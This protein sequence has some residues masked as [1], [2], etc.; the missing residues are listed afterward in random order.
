MRIQFGCVPLV[1]QVIEYQRA[2]SAGFF[3]NMKECRDQTL[4]ED[5]QRVFGKKYALLHLNILYPTSFLSLFMY[6]LFVCLD[7]Q[8]IG[9]T[10]W[11]YRTIH[12]HRIEDGGDILQD[13]FT[14]RPSKCLIFKGKI[15]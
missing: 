2:Q 8:G 10:Y 6:T 3:K 7:L 11:I 4:R 5:G 9:R 12:L 14:A 13:S 1:G 15:I